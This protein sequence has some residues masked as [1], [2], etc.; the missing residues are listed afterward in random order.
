MK[1][2]LGI[3]IVAAA[4][5]LGACGGS[6]G[7]EDL[8][9]GVLKDPATGLEWSQSDNGA[10]I[11]WPAARDWCAARGAGWRL[12]TIEELAALYDPSGAK[13]A[14]CGNYDGQP[15]TCNV[16]PLFRLSGPTPWTRSDDIARPLI[17]GLSPL[18]KGPGP[19]DGIDGARALCVRKG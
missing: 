4:L 12:A 2:P 18:R 19:I 17:F 1:R 16:S 14:P 8:G 5:A 7:I 10:D 11:D 15:M 6:R 9:G 13:H 3:A